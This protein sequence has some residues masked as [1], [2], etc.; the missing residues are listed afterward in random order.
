MKC[1]NCNDNE[2][3]LLKKRVESTNKYDI[4][5][6]VLKCQK[7]GNVFKE[8]VYHEKPV[9]YRLIVSKFEDSYKT[10]IDLIPN[11]KLSV[12]DLLQSEKEKVIVTSIETKNNARVEST[13]TN[14][15]R[16]IWANSQEIPSR[17]GVSVDEKGWISAYKVELPREYKIAVGDILK[18][19][20]HVFVVKSIKTLERKIRKGFAKSKVI[21]RIYGSPTEGKHKKDLTKNIVSKTKLTKED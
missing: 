15:I 1:P 17:I 9:P 2:L 13:N 6:L 19:E 5:K 14:D 12:G 7:C 16:T 21:K 20:N 11:I 18:I 10:T 3:E 8:N 4:D